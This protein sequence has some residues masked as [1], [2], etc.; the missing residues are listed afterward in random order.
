MTASMI[1]ITMTTVVTTAM[2]KLC[3]DL[4]PFLLGIHAYLCSR[5]DM[6]TRRIW[7]SGLR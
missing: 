7:T 3:L 2:K 5:D 4:D 6:E 1:I